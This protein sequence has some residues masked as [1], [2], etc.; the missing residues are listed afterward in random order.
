MSSHP[1]SGFVLK[2]MDR[3]AEAHIQTLCREKESLEHTALNGVFLP[4]LPPQDAGNTM[5]KECPLPVYFGGS[6]FS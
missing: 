4:N 5:N 2:Q 3:D 6:V 1:S